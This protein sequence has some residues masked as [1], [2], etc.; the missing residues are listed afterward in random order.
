VQA[1]NEQRT[2]PPP[3]GQ[4]DSEQ[5]LN[6]T[7][8]LQLF[9]VMRLGSVILT[10]ILLAK[11]GLSTADIGA[12]EMLLYIG[13]T[14]TF[15]WL[16]G[17]LMGMTPFYSKLEGDDRK[18]FIFNNFLVFCGISAGLF[19]LLFFGEKIV[20]PLLTG[21]VEVPHFRLFCLYLL[22]NLPTFPV[23]Y[24]YLLKEKPRHIVGW[25]MAT[26][27]LHVVA[28]FLP[29]KMGYGLGGGL[30]ALVVLSALKLHWVLGLIAMFGKVQ[31]R[32]DLIRRYLTFS[33]PLMLNVLVG[34]LVI[35]FDVWLVSWYFKDETTFAIFRYGSREFP[36]ATALA[37]ALGTAIIP[38]LSADFSAGLA[39]L[40]SK[41]R[42]LMHLLFPLTIIML[43]LSKPLFPIVFNPDFAASAPLFNI[44][45]LI[46]AS[47]VLLPNAIVLAKGEPRAI[48]WVGIVE[49]IVKIALG[50]LFIHWWGL[51]GVAWS[52]VLAFWVEKLGLIWF[53]EKKYGVK[54]REWL[55][56]QW[57]WGYLTALAAA[58]MIS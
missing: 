12:Y 7:R 29:I 42:R 2:P 52:A 1:A 37:T 45:L 56:L 6:T 20:T 5:L 38:R 36:L 3:S 27:G 21:Q 44:Y 48:F 18:A 28:I 50:F 51:A 57:Y 25:G 4:A 22:F 24:I 23:E 39:A 46:T 33:S 10:S 15:F 40:K 9:Q 53:L 14:L 31:W 35:L 43:F 26:F 16:N 13:T 41:T 47:R 58:F 49:L 55:D 8:A 34:N 30:T 19:W 17:L 11:S 32:G 54:T